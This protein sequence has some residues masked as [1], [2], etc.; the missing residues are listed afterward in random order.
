MAGSS[1]ESRLRAALATG[2]R[3]CRPCPIGRGRDLPDSRTSSSSVAATPGSTRPGSSRARRRGHAPRGADARL[4]RRRRAT[5]G[6]STRATSGARGSSIKRYGEET[7]TGPLPARR[8]TATRL[9]KRL[10]ADE[11]DRLRVPRVRLPRARLGA[12][13]RRRS[14]AAAGETLAAFGVDGDVRPARAAPRGDRDRRLPRRPGRARAAACSTRASYFAGLA[15]A[16]DRA[17]ADLHEGVRATADP[18]PGR[19]PLRRRDRTRRDPGARRL[20]RH[21]RLHRR[22]RARRCAAGSSRSGATSSRPSRSPRSW[23]ASSRRRAG[24]SS[25]RRTSCSTG[26]SR[27]TAG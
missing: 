11:V 21:E 12:R 5:A 1:P 16:A 26:T 10:I 22:R 2:A 9:V 13:A 7:R 14:R 23:R 3:R 8:S 18:P 25:T 17:G 27:R 24:R 19:R 6:S 15:A 4:G 20:R